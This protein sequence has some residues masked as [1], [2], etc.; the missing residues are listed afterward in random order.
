MACGAAS[1]WPVSMACWQAARAPSGSPCSESRTPRL[2]MA[3]GAASGSSLLAA[4][5]N[6]VWVASKH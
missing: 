3:C 1:G 2:N 6:N 5:E 4:E